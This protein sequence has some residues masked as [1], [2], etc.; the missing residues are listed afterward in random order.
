MRLAGVSV[1]GDNTSRAIADA[2]NAS[3]VDGVWARQDGAVWLPGDGVSRRVQGLS[4][5]ALAD[6]LYDL[7][8]VRWPGGSFHYETAGE[9][10]RRT[11]VPIKG[12]GRTIS[13]ALEGSPERFA[14]IPGA[15]GQWRW[16]PPTE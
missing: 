4:G 6:A 10:L 8:R 5:K 13:A 16:L 2:L 12:T 14:R 11:G 9:A 3:Q 1:D 7:V 15:R